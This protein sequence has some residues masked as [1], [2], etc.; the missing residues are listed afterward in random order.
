MNSREQRV[1]ATAALSLTLSL[2]LVHNA[3]AKLEGGHG[4]DAIYGG[5]GNDTFFAWDGFADMLNG[6]PG[7]DRAFRDKLDRIYAM[8]RAG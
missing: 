3:H 7:T 5:A 8:E 2:I 1:K 4:R 6:G